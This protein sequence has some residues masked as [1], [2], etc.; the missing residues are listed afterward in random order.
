[1]IDTRVKSPILA[2]FIRYIFFFIT[3]FAVYIFLKGHNAPGGG[4][5]AGIIFAISLV[6]LNMALSA[7]EMKQILH[8]DPLQ[9]ATTGLFIAYGTAIAPVFFGYPFMLHKMIHLHVP[10]LGN[11]HVGTPVL[12]DFGVFLVVVGVTTKM[13][14]TF[15][16]SSDSDINTLAQD[17]S[18]LSNTNEEPVVAPTNEQATTE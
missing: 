6:I 16:H 13:T 5:I 11:L 12:L 7:D 15:S 9:I 17:E 18:G 3:I 1:M 4:F 8:Y 14:F 10:L 2:F